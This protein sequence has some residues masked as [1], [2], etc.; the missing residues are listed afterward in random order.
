MEGAEAEDEV[1]AGDADDLAVW[2]QTRQLI[3]CDVIAGI[4]KSGDDYGFV[5]DVKIGV[6]GGEALAVEIDGRGHR[7]SFDAEGTAILV[8][9]SLQQREIFFQ[10]RKVR[11]SRIVFDDGYDR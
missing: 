8:I 11:I 5:G 9:H 6:A 7:E 3:Q 4:V 2:K 1:A 10:R